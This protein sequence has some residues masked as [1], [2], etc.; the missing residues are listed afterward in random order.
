MQCPVCNATVADDVAYCTE[1]GAAVSGDGQATQGSGQD[2]KSQGGQQS[3]GGQAGGQPQDGGQ[4]NQA[5]GGQAPGG[6]GSGGQAPGGQGGQ[7]Q[8][9]QGG[10]PPGGQGG[11]S[12]SGQAQAPPAGG[13]QQGHGAP[14]QQQYSQGPSIV[15]TAKEQ[16]AK[17]PWK[18]G[19]IGG[20][21]IYGL[22]FGALAVLASTGTGFRPME[23]AMAV[24]V[25]LA[26]FVSAT[27]IAVALVNVYADLPSEVSNSAY[28]AA[29][30]PLVFVVPWLLY[31]TGRQFAK[32]R[33]LEEDD[34]VGYLAT[35][36][37]V[38]FGTLPIMLLL[39]VLFGGEI[40]KNILM[41]GIVIPGLAGAAGGLAA[42]IFAGRSRAA[43]WGV[44]ILLGL[45]GFVLV[46]GLTF[47]WADPASSFAQNPMVARL[48]AA[49][50]AFVSITTFSFPFNGM[51]L[52]GLFVVLGPLLAVGY[53]RASGDSEGEA[54]ILDGARDG[55]SLV[56]GFSTFFFITLSSYAVLLTPAVQDHV[57]SPDWL[58]FLPGAASSNQFAAAAA[59]QTPAALP[60]AMLQ[61]LGDFLNAFLIGAVVVPIVVGGLGGAIAGY[62]AMDR[63]SPMPG[64]GGQQPGS[65]QPRGAGQTGQPQSPA[66]GPAGDRS[67]AAGQG[68]NA[69]TAG[70]PAASENE[71]PT[72]DDGAS[73]GNGG[74]GGAGGAD[75]TAGG[76][77][78][79]SGGS[80]NSG[81]SAGGGGGGGE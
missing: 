73:G 78:G 35:G 58:L 77:G 49:L 18:S 80:G 9:G 6:Q 44:G 27:D 68:P 79:S 36:A 11:Q 32:W 16:F 38:V 56:A 3:G 37:T 24:F 1:C 20:V 14:P 29:L 47:L 8:G 70:H 17:L 33:D 42:L 7:P 52:L 59:A 63:T 76:G 71:P 61:T 48:I 30:A 50:A 64:G 53:L 54:S 19:I 22:V 62:R 13:G 45:V 67:Q 5:G 46:F 12:R 69:P 81:G 25:G 31:A 66:G 26:T 39:T 65:P 57:L 51:G 28:D 60:V 21:L 23:S 15:D 34:V 41:A 4:A 74:A 10:A 55:A 72:A 43:S 75:G 40:G 2:S